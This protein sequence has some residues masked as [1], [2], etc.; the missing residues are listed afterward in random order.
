MAGMMANKPIKLMRGKDVV[1]GPRKPE[2]KN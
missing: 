2:A 1:N